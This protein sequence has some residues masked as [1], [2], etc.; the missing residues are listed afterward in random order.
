MSLGGS[1]VTLPINPVGKE[2]GV[3]WVVL[4]GSLPVDDV[5][6]GSDGRVAAVIRLT[7]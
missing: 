3:G 6:N 4:K 1:Q 7:F 2:V 5:N